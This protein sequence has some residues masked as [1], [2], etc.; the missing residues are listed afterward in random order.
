MF[1]TVF[2]VTKEIFNRALTRRESAKCR[3]YLQRRGSLS[4]KADLSSVC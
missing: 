4:G 1:V 2:N 3:S